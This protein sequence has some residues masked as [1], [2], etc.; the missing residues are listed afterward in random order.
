MMQRSV[1]ASGGIGRHRAAR[2]I[3]WLNGCR[4][5]GSVV[6]WRRTQMVLFRAKHARGED[7]R[8]DVHQ[9]G[10]GPDVIHNFNADGFEALYPKYKGG[11]P[12]LLRT[13]APTTPATNSRAA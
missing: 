9:C 1:A 2:M 6:T 11:R 7:R 3:T 4:G 8:G 12:A 10:P 5:T 13:T